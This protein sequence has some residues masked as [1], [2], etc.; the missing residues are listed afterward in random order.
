MTTKSATHEPLDHHACTVIY[1]T[2]KRKS[3]MENCGVM[4]SKIMMLHYALV[5]LYIMITKVHSR[6]FTS[7]YSYSCDF[8]NLD[9]YT[10]MRNYH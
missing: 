7:L 9:S 4:T 1:I 6:L 5:K 2:V 8:T 3:K 10:L